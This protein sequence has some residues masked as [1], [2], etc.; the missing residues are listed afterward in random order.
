MKR[1]VWFYSLCATCFLTGF[2]LGLI[3]GPMP[4]P[5]NVWIKAIFILVPV[6]AI[7]REVQELC[8]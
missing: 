8:Q 5:L 4:D 1:I 3:C 2:L 6:F 7:T